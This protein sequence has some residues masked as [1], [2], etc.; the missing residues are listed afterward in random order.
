MKNKT[1]AFIGIFSLIFSA[2]VY[3]LYDYAKPDSSKNMLDVSFIVILLFVVLASIRLWTRSKLL[4]CVL[5][6]ATLCYF[7][8]L[9]APLQFSDRTFA[10]FSYLTNGIGVV[11]SII[12]ITRL[13][14][15]ET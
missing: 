8:I 14:R 11:S 3:T 7:L 1:I 13:Y 10:W 9:N 4:I 12:A 2:L 6:A 5:T 15:S